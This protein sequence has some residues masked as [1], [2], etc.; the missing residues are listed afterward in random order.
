MDAAGFAA[1][2][3]EGT[4]SLPRL[5]YDMLLYAESLRTLQ[6]NDQELTAVRRLMKRENGFMFRNY[7]ARI[8]V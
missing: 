5:W 7:M 6:R 8:G 4:V 2:L 3:G 1:M